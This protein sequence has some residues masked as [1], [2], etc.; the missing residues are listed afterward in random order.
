[1]T[2]TTATELRPG[3]TPMSKWAFYSR[4]IYKLP[5]FG[6]ATP[7]DTWRWTV[8]RPRLDAGTQS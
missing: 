6:Y 3:H 5:V 1:M 4:Q 8:R 2:F 7:Y